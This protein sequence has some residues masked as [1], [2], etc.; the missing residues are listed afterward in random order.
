VC[1]NINLNMNYIGYYRV[2]TKKQWKSGLGLDAQK[3]AVKNYVKKQGGEIL[4]EFI[5][6]ES[7]KKNDRPEIEKALNISKENKINARDRKIKFVVVDNP[8]ATNFTLHI[9]VA[10]A[11]HER[12]MIS[13][14]VIEALVQAKKRGIILGKNGKA[15]SKK[16][17]KDADYFALKLKPLIEE[18]RDRQIKTVSRI[19]DLKG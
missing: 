12:E 13:K 18:I 19:L 4:D 1:I 14:R 16:N 3:E 8:N 7:G 9:L 10:V 15:L 5:E 2:S 11:E 17:K 6:V